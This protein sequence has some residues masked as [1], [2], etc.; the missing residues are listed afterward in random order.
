MGVT[1]VIC[2]RELLDLS[3]G[4][5]FL[6]S[7]CPKMFL[8]YLVILSFQPTTLLYIY[9]IFSIFVLLHQQ[10]HGQADSFEFDQMSEEETLLG[11]HGMI[12]VDT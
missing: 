10:R 4:F 3:R 6:F 11:S 12:G 5:V 8:S 1:L 2:L 7:V 9:L